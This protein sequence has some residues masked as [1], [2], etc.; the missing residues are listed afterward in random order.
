MPQTALRKKLENTITKRGGAVF[1]IASAEDADKIKR[2]RMVEA[3]FEGWSEKVTSVM[4]DAKSVVVFGI[5]T[6]GDA[7]EL[8][9]RRSKNEWTYPGYAPLALIARDLIEVLSDEGY[10]GVIPPES[11]PRKPI[12]VLAG[13]GAY[14][15][16]SMIL[17]EEYGLSLRLEVVITDAPLKKDS[18]F[19]KDLCTDC[20]RCVRSCPTRALKPYVLD[21]DRCL[22][23]I[24]ETGT[25]DTELRKIV[26]KQALW[27][28]P[29]TIVMCTICQMVCPFTSAERRKNT[30][31]R[32]NIISQ[33]P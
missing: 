33:Q 16:N 3:E 4:P 2:V 27:L 26:D 31:K 9:V 21:V 12:A 11:V 10:K 14:G 29:N 1:G 25:S 32:R 8:S 17:T 23:H 24:T 7:D 6:F 19:E 22:V 30:V 20:D 28:T 18:P 15:K 13:I 5:Q